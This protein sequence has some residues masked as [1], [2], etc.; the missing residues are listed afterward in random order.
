MFVQILEMQTVFTSICVFRWTIYNLSDVYVLFRMI[1]PTS[2]FDY[3]KT[4]IWKKNDAY[5]MITYFFF[6]IGKFK[7]ICQTGIKVSADYSLMT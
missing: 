2:L 5:S 7:F 1:R 3:E 6:K 4:H